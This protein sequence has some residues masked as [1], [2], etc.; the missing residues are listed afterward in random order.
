MSE[1]YQPRATSSRTTY[2]LGGVAALIVVA[3][4]V[5]GLLWNSRDDSGGGV[6]EA[7]LSE[8]AALI[9]GE[10][11]APQTIDVFED[12]MCPACR[13]F[14]QQS[15]TA[16]T[17]AINNGSL[18]VRYH[19]LT[20]LDDR[21]ASGDYS[22]RAAGAAQCVGAGE[23]KEVFERFHAA[24]FDNQPEEGGDSDPSNADMARL[25][26]DQG[27]SA[28]TRE[29]VATGAKVAEAQEAAEQSR[30]QLEKASG[31]VGTPTVLSGGQPVDGIMNGTGW[32]DAL[33]ADN[34]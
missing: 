24:L 9:I 33:L 34:G 27:A 29:C 21:S 23:D 8:N 28:Q 7:V 11:S 4:V 26:A 13:E 6:D 17:Q 14:E 3:L 22:T 32:L 2:I 30:T 16:I 20:F 31:Q 15:G 19:M 5:G 12:F 10:P 18:R 1:K 25:A